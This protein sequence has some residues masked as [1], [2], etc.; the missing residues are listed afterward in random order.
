MNPQSK[1]G[2]LSMRNIMI[3]KK[4]AERK[5]FDSADYAM[6]QQIPSTNDAVDSGRPLNLH[7]STDPAVLHRVA[8]S[9]VD[10]VQS[11]VVQI[12][13]AAFF[14][15]MSDDTCMATAPNSPLVEAMT[16]SPANRQISASSSETAVAN[17]QQQNAKYGALSA[18]NIILRRKL[19][20]TTTHFDSADYQLQKYGHGNGIEGT[21][22]NYSVSAPV[23]DDIEVAGAVGA[24]VDAQVAVPAQLPAAPTNYG[25]LCAQNILIRKKLKE[26]KRFDS[27]DY[28]MEHSNPSTTS[29]SA[30]AAAAQAARSITSDQH[31]PKLLKISVDSPKAAKDGSSSRDLFSPTSRVAARNVFLQRRLQERKRFDSADYFQEKQQQQQQQHP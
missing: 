22:S 2:G 3:R 17:S 10:H 6:Q 25:K 20:H 27:A 12:G 14:D 7:I 4:L 13:M 26:R 18:R 8:S 23:N 21:V 5:R 30:A 19:A 16:L 9:H 31:Q 11:P 28:S 1:Y 15:S 29:A 24:T